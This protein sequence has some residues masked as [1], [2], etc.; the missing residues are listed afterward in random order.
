MRRIVME[1][2]RQRK[3]FLARKAKKDKDPSFVRNVLI[4]LALSEG[5][6]TG[7]VAGLFRVHRTTLWRVA[8]RFLAGDVRGLRDGRSMRRPI[9]A[10]PEVAS[11]LERLVRASPPQFG[12]ARPTW[13]RQL[14]AEEVERQIGVRLGLTTVG[15][16]LARIGAGWNRPRPVVKCPWPEDKRKARLREI[17]RMLARLPPDEVALFEDEAELHL[18]PKIG[19]DWMIR[20]CQKQLLTPGRNQKGYLAGAVEAG[21]DKL[22][23]VRGRRKDSAL[24]ICLLRRLDELYQEARRIHLVVDNYCIHISKAT[25]GGP[26]RRWEG[27]SSCISC[28][29]TV[30]RKTRWNCSGCTCTGTSPA[31]TSAG[32]W[33]S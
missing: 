14:L 5:E 4:V 17:A 27:G 2:T 6:R 30:R 3:R 9:K 32:S 16:V 24:F 21:G 33:K 1:L 19:F 7:T 15:R 26:W 25:R 8:R 22:V 11:L 13:T 29:P 18:N 31:T 23:W 20:G 28:L 10:T 12:Y